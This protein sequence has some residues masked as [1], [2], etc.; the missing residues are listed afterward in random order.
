[1]RSVILLNVGVC[2][3]RPCEPKCVKGGAAAV[4]GLAVFLAHV[5]RLHAVLGIKDQ[6]LILS[7]DAW[8]CFRD[9]I[10]NHSLANKLNR[11]C[12]SVT[13]CMQMVK[14]VLIQKLKTYN[15]LRLDLGLL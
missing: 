8:L 1:M 12:C 9:I 13:V 2:F 10:Q 15:K 6:L 11:H 14:Q 5:E 4:F 3:L 7:A